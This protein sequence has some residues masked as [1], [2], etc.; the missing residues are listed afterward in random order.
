MTHDNEPS[1]ACCAACQAMRTRLNT[2]RLL[3]YSVLVLASLLLVFLATSNLAARAVISKP[4]DPPQQQGLLA[5]EQVTLLSRHL[6][7]GL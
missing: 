7:E 1:D 3:L 6:T 2:S 5:Y 4:A